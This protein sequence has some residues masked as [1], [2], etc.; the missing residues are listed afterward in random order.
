MEIERGVIAA[1]ARADLV[2]FD[3][4]LRP[5]AVMVGGRFVLGDEE[6]GAR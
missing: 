4:E 1:G 3:Q 2:L 5:Q 6:L